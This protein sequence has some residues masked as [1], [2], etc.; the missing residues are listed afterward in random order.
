MS[1]SEQSD[2]RMESDGSD[3]YEAPAKKTVAKGKVTKAA[4]E[5]KAKVS[6]F[7]PR[8]SISSS[9]TNP[10]HPFIESSGGQSTCQT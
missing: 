10:L 8:Q 3:F 5:P 2:F 1:D 6:C 7:L 9:H 4:A